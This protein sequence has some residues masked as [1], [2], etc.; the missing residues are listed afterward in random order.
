MSC[1]RLLRF[2]LPALALAAC[3]EEQSPAAPDPGPAGSVQ[4]VAAGH[5]VVN[6]LADPGDGTCNAAQCTLREAIND[7]QSTEIT[8]AAGLTGPITLAPIGDGGGRLEIDKPLTITG[9]SSLIA[10]RGRNPEQAFP[11]LVIGHGAKVTLRNLIIRRGTRGIVNRGTLTVTNCQIVGN[12]EGIFSTEILTLSNSLISGNAG[13]GVSLRGLGQATLRRD[14]IAGNSGRGLVVAS[15]AAELIGS[16]VAGNS[17]GGILNNTARLTITRSTIANNSTTG[18]GG[19]ILNIA[20][21][22]FRR[23]SAQL[24]LINSTVSGNSADSGGGIA[25]LPDRSFAGVSLTNTTLTGNS[26]SQQGG[27]IFQNCCAPSDD[28]D[29]GSIGL[30]NSI[31][32]QNSAPAGPDAL[33]QQGFVSSSFSLIGDGSGSGIT[34]GVDGNKVGTAAAPIAARLGPLADNGGLTHTHALMAGSPAIDAGSAAECPSTDQR[35]V[36]RPQGAGCD[37]GSY[38]RD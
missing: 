23:V 27:G 6:S 16:T 26:A 9:P 8:F 5:K 12:G 22:V 34:N 4:S 1:S 29:N 14:R 32:A 35:G 3:G 30:T 28:E 37:M 21:D 38:E 19:G 24:T 7:P 11:V 13:N 2:A 20:D 25:N 36:S 33:I 15:S 31:V 18:E 10:I 17:G